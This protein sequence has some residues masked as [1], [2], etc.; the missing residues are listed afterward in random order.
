MAK[1]LFEIDTEDLFDNTTAKQD[2]EIFKEMVERIPD[3]ILVTE[4][5]DRNL[6]DDVFSNATR[7]EQEEL[8]LSNAEDFGYKIVE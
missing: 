1:I 8:F 3:D 4:V 5:T 7:G 6:L 2:N